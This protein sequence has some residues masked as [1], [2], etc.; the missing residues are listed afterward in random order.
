MHACVCIS[1]YNSHLEFSCD[2]MVVLVH[3]REEH[4]HTETAV[5]SERESHHALDVTGQLR[6]VCLQLS[7]G[8]KHNK[9]AIL[10]SVLKLAKWE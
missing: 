10:F 2:G 4:L 6:H 7:E 5:I 8:W 9:N 1:S 3:I